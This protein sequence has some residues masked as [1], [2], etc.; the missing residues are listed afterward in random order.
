MTCSSASGHGFV[1]LL[2]GDAVEVA[3]AEAVK[4]GRTLEATVR[5]RYIEGFAPAKM[6]EAVAVPVGSEKV[7]MAPARRWFCREGTKDTPRYTHGGLSL[8]EVV[9]PGVVLRRVTAK[10]A[11]VELI[12]L[13]VVIPADEDTVVDV[14]VC[15]RNSGNCEV[16]FEVRV[17]NNLGEELLIK[18]SR[19]APATAHKETAHVLAKYKEGS[20]RE[21]D[22]SNTVTGVTLRLRHTDL[23][24]DWRDALD[25]LITVPVKVMPKVVKLGTDALKSFD[26]I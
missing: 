7:W 19:L 3:E 25:G 18:R 26:D 1:E 16:E 12:D 20:D 13:R 10:V 9:V 17:L 14:P 11:R 15:V 6:P 2:P 22:L 5:W 4:V 8:A 24:G 23:E 21:I